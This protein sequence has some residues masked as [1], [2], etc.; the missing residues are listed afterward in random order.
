MHNKK[1][2]FNM[3]NRDG[4]GPD[5]KGS[6]TGMKRGRCNPERES[7]SQT[8]GRGLRRRATL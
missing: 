1:E 2:E 5:G 4:T 7:V 6:M 8:K 3:P